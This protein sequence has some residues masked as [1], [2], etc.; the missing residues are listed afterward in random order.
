MLY[1]GAVISAVFVV[2][3]CARHVGILLVEW[4]PQLAVHSLKTS[5]TF[6]FPFPYINTPDGS[7]KSLSQSVVGSFKFEFVYS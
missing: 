3:V 6:T 4:G 1:L 5:N 2:A 7:L